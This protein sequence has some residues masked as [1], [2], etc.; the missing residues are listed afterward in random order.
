M[1]IV[2]NC[3]IIDFIGNQAIP[4]SGIFMAKDPAI[5][6][7]TK[8]LPFNGASGELLVSPLQIKPETVVAMHIARQVQ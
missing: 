6:S 2:E 4:S 3:S 7:I 8:Y 1:P 5:E